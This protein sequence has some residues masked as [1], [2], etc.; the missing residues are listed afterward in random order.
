MVND[1]FKVYKDINCRTK[2][3]I[4]IGIV[5]PVRTG[6]STFINNF[7]ENLIIPNIKDEHEKERA[8]D[9]LP[10]SGAG[11]T[12]TTTEPKFIPKNAVKIDITENQTAYVRLI[13][14][15][16]FMVDGVNGHL[17][18]NAERMVKTPWSINAIP[19]SQA[20]YIGTQKVINDH[21]TIGLVITTDG[22]FSDIPR[23]NYI[24][25]EDEAIENLQKINKP[26]LVI[27]NTTKP[28]SQEAIQIANEISQKHNVV[29]MPVNCMQ[30]KQN[31]I[32]NI[33]SKLLSV[34]PIT[35]IE[36]E[37]PIWCKLLDKT[38]PIN[39]TMQ[40]LAKS[41]LKHFIIIND[42][43]QIDSFESN[44]Y[45]NKL[46]IE[47]INL[48]NGNIKI[49]IQLH[50]SLYYDIL[51]EMTQV[52][53]KNDY[54]LISIIKELSSMK[55]SL[56]SHFDAIDKVNHT[57]YSVVVPTKDD[58]SVFEPE[59]IKHGNKYGIKIKAIATS[60]HM[61]KAPIETEI[62]PIVGTVEQAKDLINFITNKTTENKDGIW[63][64]NIFGK[65]VEQL[66]N[67]GID[68]KINRMS[69]DTRDKMQQ[70]LKKIVNESTGGVICIII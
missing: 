5:G 60:I 62:A 48:E 58:I 57:G 44:E 69:D 17:E 68:M 45:I 21:S 18:N 66:I 65:S 55:K 7:M 36:F 23:Q 13:D 70:T 61:I 28:Y 10:Q 30:L 22:S 34:F 1:N 46:I 53:I 12:I 25:A 6:K 2:G 15:V 8:I 67:E 50:T 31:D 20:A 42:V 16:G 35:Q 64:T 14:C 19:F 27:V 29:A 56:E 59:L 40:E 3:E 26:F 39:K 47:N 63:N 37:Y 11:K 38:H 51:S 43:Q 54:Q 24:Q 52:P 32:N 33:M 49:K 41:I 9:E 4:Y